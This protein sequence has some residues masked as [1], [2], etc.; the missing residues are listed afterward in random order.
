MAGLSIKSG[1]DRFSYT[2]RVDNY[3][4]FISSTMQAGISIID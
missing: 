2:P 1:S 4:A 3:Y